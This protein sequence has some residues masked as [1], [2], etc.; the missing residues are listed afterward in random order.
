MLTRTWNYTVLNGG[1]V[2]SDLRQ[3]KSVFQE[4]HR[5][6]TRLRDDVVVYLSML[7]GTYLIWR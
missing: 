2:P 3:A 5:R 7:A 6:G 1:V 4:G